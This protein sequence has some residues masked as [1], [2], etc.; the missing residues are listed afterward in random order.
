MTKP[1]LRNL[2]ANLPAIAFKPGVTD[3]TGD[4][5]AIALASYFEE[6]DDRPKDDPPS[7]QSDS[8]GT[9]TLEK[10]DDAIDRIIEAISEAGK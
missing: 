2:I 9:W 3:S 7:W 10:V 8:W 1:E 4:N 6:H 5:I